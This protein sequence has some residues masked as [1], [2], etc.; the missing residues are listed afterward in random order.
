MAAWLG[1]LL[2]GCS[3]P[4]PPDCDSV[5]Y[6]DADGD[7]YGGDAGQSACEAPDGHVGA[8]G[9]CDDGDVAVSP[10]AVEVC[11]GVD[12]DC[13]GAEDE[14]VADAPVWYADADG[15]GFGDG[16]SSQRSCCLLYTSDAADE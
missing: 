13:D 14:D 8:G 6:A 11:N 7:G 5:W 9:D 16:G 12:D 4:E 15:D 1:L 10:A 3:A 2:T